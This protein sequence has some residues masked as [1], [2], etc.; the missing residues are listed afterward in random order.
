MWSSLAQKRT[1]SPQRASLMQNCRVEPGVVRTRPGLTPIAPA[2]SKVTG[3]FN[4]I[5]PSG[6]N[7]VLYQDG[8]AI[9]AFTQPYGLRTLLPNAGYTYRP[10]FAQFGKWT[11]FCGYR[12]GQ[13]NPNDVN[14]VG[15]GTMPC[16]VF[17]GMFTDRAFRGPV[18]LT[19]AAAVDGGDGRSTAG[20]HY[21]GIV[22]QNRSGFAGVPTTTVNGQPIAFTLAEDSRKINVSVTIPVLTDGGGDAMVYLIMTRADNPSA[23]Y[24][25]PNTGNSIGEAAVGDLF[26]VTLKFVVDLSDEDLAASAD[27]ANDQFLYLTEDA[28]GNPPFKPNFVV[29]YGTRM[30]YGV[31][32]NLYISEKSNPQ[33]LTGDQHLISPPENRRIAYAFPLSGS[34]DLYLTGDRWT[35]RVTD[36]GDVPATWATPIQVSDALG[37][38]WPSCVC[39]RTRGNYAWIVTEGG[40]YVFTGSY[41]DKPV[42]YLVSDLWARV[43]WNAAQ[44]IE[45]ADDVARQLF[46]VA[47]PLDGS[48]E[49]THLFCIDYSNGLSYDQVDISLDKLHVS[50]F[51]SIGVVKDLEQGG[52]A[53]AGSAGVSSLWIGLSGEAPAVPPPVPPITLPATPDPGSGN[54]LMNSDGLVV[55]AYNS[56]AGRGD[57][58]HQSSGTS[59]GQFLYILGMLEAFRVTGSL[60]A[61]ANAQL[62]LSHV[63][64]VLYRGHPIPATVDAINI[65]APHWLFNV[66]I[67]FATAEIR[68]LDTFVFNNGVATVPETYGPV[69]YIFQAHSTGATLLWE[70]PYAPLTSGTAYPIASTSYSAGVGTTVTLVTPYSGAL[71]VVYSTQSGPVI[72][73]GTPYEA[74]PDWRVL[75]AG[76]IASACDTYVWAY[77]VFLT[78]AELLGSNW[79]AAAEATRQ[80]AAIVYDV[81]DARDWLKLAYTRNPFSDGS[82]FQFNSRTT[83]ALITCDTSGRVLFN[84][85]AGAGETQYGNASINDNYN[86]GDSTTVLIGSTA[87]VSVTLYIDPTSSYVPENRYAVTIE[88]TGEALQDL[89]LTA[90]DFKNPANEPIPDGMTVYTFGISD[91]ANIAHTITLGRVRQ[92]PNKNIAYYPGAL[93]FT[94]NFLGDPAT[95]IDWRGPAYVGYQSPWMWKKIGN[96]AGIANSV[97]MMADAQTAWRDQTGQ[98]DSGPFAPVF[99]FARSD[100]QQYGPPDTFG[101]VGPDPNTKWAGYQYRPLAEVAELYAVS[102]GSEPYYNLAGTIADQFLSYIDAHWPEVTVTAGPPTD[103]PEGSAGVT[104]YPEPHFVALILRAALWMD[105]AKRPSQTGTMNPVYASLLNKSIAFWTAWY[106]DDGAMAGTFSSDVASQTWFGFWHGEILRTLAHLTAWATTNQQPATVTMVR[107]WIDGMVG[108][109]RSSVAPASGAPPPDPPITE[110]RILHIDQARRNDAGAA[111]ESIWK[112]GLVRGFN[113]YASRM[114]RVGNLDLWIRGEGS[115]ITTIAGPDN[116]RTVTPRLLTPGG[117]AAEL[118]AEPGTMYQEKFDLSRI[119]NYTVEVKTDAVDE[120]FELSGFTG[121]T[122]QDLFNK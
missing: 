95:L 28:N 88:L 47:A 43:N 112:S 104:N 9:R 58:F 24:F 49:P 65:F 90:A 66:K 52:S 67:P 35:S 72:A 4:R 36:S 64:A 15:F 96:E 32:T 114:I 94:A 5:G 41:A 113:E 55:N 22:Y 53:G 108:F 19:G 3:L 115:L 60:G 85:E 16:H 92:L 62:A 89:T 30:C 11:Y 23:W 39:Y 33:A 82:R 81:N 105:Q 116:R 56:E 51:S 69:R 83:P 29:T 100:A 107:T 7:S 6:A 45:T 12:A 71:T 93:P 76:E 122:K 84:I 110:M 102:N 61:L 117:V 70:N 18:S 8:I 20:T 17:D 13:S 120:W 97:Q 103:Y 80:Q 86:T 48:G 77:K 37:S 118:S 26:G 2:S 27:S 40:P 91:Q 31:N 59:E 46:Y 57:Y 78:A 101:W 106:H 54:Q 10:T 111:I 98:P 50:T 73:P 119:E 99:Y 121:Y 68:Y 74:W 63:Y 79:A 21:F 109:A 1:G 75:D 14:F 87:P 44:A 34:T 38:P 25:V 42:T